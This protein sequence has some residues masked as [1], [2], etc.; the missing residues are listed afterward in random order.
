VSKLAETNPLPPWFIGT[1]VAALIAGFFLVRVAYNNWF[2][3]LAVF[4]IGSAVMYQFWLYLFARQWAFHLSHQ[5]PSAWQGD[6]IVL[7]FLVATPLYLLYRN[8][9]A[10]STPYWVRSIWFQIGAFVAGLLIAVYFR[11]TQRNVYPPDVLNSYWKAW[12]D[13]FAFTFLAAVLIYGAPAI[14]YSKWGLRSLF[15]DGLHWNYQVLIIVPILF[16]LAYFFVYLA[17]IKDRTLDVNAVSPAN[18]A[19]VYGYNHATHTVTG[20]YVVAKGSHYA[21]PD[22][23]LTVVNTGN[24]K[25][26]RWALPNTA[27]AHP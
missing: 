12:H 5:Y 18:Y 26:W 3:M 21:Y 13:V 27:A 10:D 9:P 23:R 25:D 17:G 16:G 20:P 8:M 24:Q 1:L 2:Y 19:A 6:L 7:P 4:L 14:W 15:K 22:G 11:G